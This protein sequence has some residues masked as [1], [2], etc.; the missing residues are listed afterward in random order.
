VET[1]DLLIVG[2]GTAGLTLA[3][4]AAEAGLRTVVVDPRARENAGSAWVNGVE[5]RLWPDLGL[6]PPTHPVVHS[7]PIGFHMQS[8]TGARV[9]SRDVPVVDV[10][11]AALTVD[12]AARAEA[13]GAELRY[14]VA[15]E[16]PRFRG[17]RVV[18][19]TVRSR[20]RRRDGAT[21]GGTTELEAALTVDASGQDG[22]VRTQ[23]RRDQ[24]DTAPVAL[25]DTCVAAQ[26]VRAITDRGA[27]EAF[28]ARHGLAP[29]ETLSW[30]SVRGGY[31]ILNV[32]VDLEHGQVSFLT[33]AMLSQGQQ[34]ALDLMEEGLRRVGFAGTRISGG[35]GLIPVRRAF[36]RLV[37]PG[38]ALLGNAASQV[39][40][41]H[42]SGV[43]AGMR[44]A[45]ILAAVATDALAGPGP[46]L[47]ALWPY[48]AAYQRT[49]G[50]ICAGQEWVRRLAE[51][52]E[53]VDVGFLYDAGVIDP[54]AL[55]QSLACEPVRLSPAQL[56]ATARAARRHPRLMA[57]VVG[58][59][60]RAQA[61]VALYE[62]YPER[63]D[64]RAFARWQR[65]RTLLWAGA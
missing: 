45:A 49:R 44:G 56:A 1:T 27:A 52:F 30:S 41:A 39:F 2:A 24:A 16:S 61:A 47:D 6:P 12:L 23:L 32:A 3:W 54:G 28:L 10:D 50:A 65:L 57:R 37:G 46:E 62:R 22:V 31:S 53:A 7:E 55:T 18:G 20:A 5:R 8:V 58:A 35:G 25:A 33:G 19:A 63:W 60:A 59:A 21:A 40:P 48:A 29:G 51:T 42:G 13:A 64:P 4:K 11:M 14:E 34:S 9:T 36:D 43:A 17:A 15:V 38:W 26:Q